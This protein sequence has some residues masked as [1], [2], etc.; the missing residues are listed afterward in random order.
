MPNNFIN[1]ERTFFIGSNH[2]KELPWTGTSHYKFS[3]GREGLL[4]LLKSL[5]LKSDDIILLP[6]F[7]PE[8]IIA[9]CRIENVE[10]KFYDL[11]ETLT[12]DWGNLK[13]QLNQYKPILCIL[14]H[15]FGLVKDINKFVHLCHSNH[16]LAFEDFAHIQFK[17]SYLLDNESDFKLYSLRKIIGVPDGAVIGSNFIKVNLKYSFSPLD[18]RRLVYIVMNT[19]HLLMTTISRNHLFFK[20]WIGFWKYF[21]YFFSSYRLLMSY[22][23]NPTKISLFSDMLLSR[24]PW[25]DSIQTRNKI[26]SFYALNLNRNIFKHLTIPNRNACSMGYLVV[27]ENR[28]SL[29][30]H[31]LK[32]G[33]Q[34]V[35]FDHKWEYHHLSKNVDAAK[36]II[37]NHFLF[38]TSYSLSLKAIERVIRIANQW[39]DSQNDNQLKQTI[40]YNG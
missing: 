26:E 38:P 15:Y 27:V 5:N 16:C 2:E 33:I 12:P 34:G 7:V 40:A 32:N 14:I 19:G 23:K 36:K 37:D 28:K 31:L 1:N 25:N 21:G 20:F 3:S 22:F 35:W 17:K 9:P 30:E 24:F 13:L 4:S 39:A 29:S 18:I 8:G 6:Q 11:D 10:I